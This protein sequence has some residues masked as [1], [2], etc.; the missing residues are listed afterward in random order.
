[1][2]E[3]LPTRSV[4]RCYKQEKERLKLKSLP[5]NGSE[6]TV[7]TRCIKESKKSGHQSKTCLQSHAIY[8][9]ICNKNK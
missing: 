4:P 3:T 9:T 1:M 5:S 2:E 7:D 6:V 8:V